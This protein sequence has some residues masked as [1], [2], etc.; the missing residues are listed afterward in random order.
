MGVCLTL[1]TFGWCVHTYVPSLQLP[2]QIPWLAFPNSLACSSQ[3]LALSVLEV[4]ERDERRLVA[5]GIVL[6]TCRSLL[7]WPAALPAGD[8]AQVS[9]AIWQMRA[10]P[11]SRS[12]HSLGV[13]DRELRACPAMWVETH[14]SHCRVIIVLCHLNGIN[15]SSDEEVTFWWCVIDNILV[16]CWRREK[17]R[18]RAQSECFCERVC[19]AH[20]ETKMR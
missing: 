18:P 15:S 5:G 9:P 2:S 12:L 16:A 4:E 14:L 8:A 13:R 11:Q 20:P 3:L 17:W 6:L 7:V 10:Q 1:V 19:L